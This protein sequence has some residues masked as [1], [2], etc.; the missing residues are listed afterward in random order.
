MDAQ[1]LVNQIVL[2]YGGADEAKLNLLQSFHLS[3]N[4]FKYMDLIEQ[5]EK[6]DLDKLTKKNS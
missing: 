5:I 2:Y 3:P 4:E 6:L 1:F